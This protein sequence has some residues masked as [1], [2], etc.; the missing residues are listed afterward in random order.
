MAYHNVATSPSP[1]D[2]VMDAPLLGRTFSWRL[3]WGYH[4][5]LHWSFAASFWHQN[6][7][8]ADILSILVQIVRKSLFVCL[9]MASKVPTEAEEVS[10]VN[11]LLQIEDLV[12]K[13]QLEKAVGGFYIILAL[14][15]P[16]PYS[17]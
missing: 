1:L 14:V 17:L 3:L 12:W 8:Q 15:L 9:K 16:G 4:F 10:R 2:G 6:P 7:F 5:R 13:K 11:K